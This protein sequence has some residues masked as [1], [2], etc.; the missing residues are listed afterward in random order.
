MVA[1]S[2]RADGPPLSRRGPSVARP[3]DTGDAGPPPLHTHSRRR[4][5]SR[6]VAP[7][8]ALS[9]RAIVPA[10]RTSGAACGP[11]C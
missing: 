10:V 6:P 1:A 8:R 5:L 3:G 7:C 9:R 4:A 11:A 2:V